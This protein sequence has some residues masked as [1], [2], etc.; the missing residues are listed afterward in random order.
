MTAS[1]FRICIL[2]IFMGFGLCRDCHA[3][4]DKE[5]ERSQIQIL[6]GSDN[7]YPPYEFIE[8]DGRLT[9]FNVEL[10]RA[11]AKVVNMKVRFIPGSW[12]TIRQALKQGRIDVVSGMFYS[13]A[14]SLRYDFSVPHSIVYHSLFVRKGSRLK[15]IEDIRG[16]SIIVIDGDIMHDY[17]LSLGFKKNVIIAANNA[18]S[19]AMLSSGKHDAALLPK[20]QTLHSMA[21]LEITNVKA[22]GPLILP[23]EYCFATLKGQG[24]ISARLDQGLAILKASGEYK[25]LKKKWFGILFQEQYGDLFYYAVWCLLVLFALLLATWI[26]NRMLT[27]RLKVHTWDLS[28][29]LKAH[30]Q[31]LSV[32]G[33]KEE[34][35]R[36]VLESSSEAILVLDT[37]WVITSCNPAFVAQFGYSMQEVIGASPAMIHIN[38]TAHEKFQALAYPQVDREGVWRGEWNYR[39]REGNA[40]VVETAISVK[41]LSNGRNDGYIAVMRDITARKNAEQERIR[42]ATAIEQSADAIII[43]DIAG[44]IVFMNAA[45]ERGSGHGR[46][47]LLGSRLFFPLED[48]E[49]QV[50]F[51]QIIDRVTAGG[52][53][54]G[55]I[56][57]R[58]AKGRKIEEEVAVSPVLDQGGNICNYVVVKRD[59]T[60]VSRLERKLSQA[61]KLEAVGNLAGGIAHDF[62]NILT[63]LI[64]YA[65]MALEDDLEADSPARHDVSQILAGCY[66]AKELVEQILTFSRQSS[67]LQEPFHLI[68][69]IKETLKFLRAGL[70]ESVGLESRFQCKDDLIH[71]TQAK[72]YQLIVNLITNATQALE[73]SGG[74]ILVSVINENR[75]GSLGGD[76]FFGKDLKITVEDDGPGMAPGIR[77]KI[78]DP[79]FTTRDKSGG[80]GL[81]L[82]VVYGIVG[83]LDGKIDVESIP[84]KGSCFTVYLPLVGDRGQ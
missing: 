10:L 1:K 32:L 23:Q 74:R 63:S 62:G 75:P 49:T 29:E 2:V 73:K 4:E 58:D 72:V 14:R 37:N 56:S 8:A 76:P 28:M 33:K 57:S 41:R 44:K 65:E 22:A 38:K 78:F 55:K 26:W 27:S 82:S 50:N 45:C 7:N 5:S 71:G 13:D 20:V 66:R 69:M 17:I 77:E 16:K 84:D 31:T 59:I 83:S 67:H 81:G 25:R 6:A 48:S 18:Q 54:H 40:L 36:A 70:P 11:A 61:H 60:R 46:S 3:V 51:P 42:L 79:Y 43:T 12:A 80:S 9:G 35:L 52:V 64:G 68:P 30:Q 47:D 21:K 19:V 24:E 39:T 15:N 53:W 34:Q